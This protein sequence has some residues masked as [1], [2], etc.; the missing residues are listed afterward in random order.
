M[1][2]KLPLCGHCNKNVSATCGWAAG[3]GYS[4]L[5]EP[6]IFQGEPVCQECF[7]KDFDPPSLARFLINENKETID[8]F[9]DNNE[10]RRCGYAGKRFL[11]AASKGY[12]KV[13]REVREALK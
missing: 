12:K 13:R 11:T 8:D 5:I 1:K 2:N 9:A 4:H 6:L 10:N 7:L 3:P